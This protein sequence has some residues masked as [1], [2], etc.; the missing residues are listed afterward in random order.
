[1]KF[2]NRHV[3]YHACIALA[4]TLL[5]YFLLIKL[6]DE[7]GGVANIITIGYALTIAL[8]AILNNRADQYQG[9]FGLNYHL[10]TYIICVG[11]PLLLKACGIL[12]EVSFVGNMA[13]GWG[14]G[15]A[16]HLLIFLVRFRKRKLG[17]Y[18]KQE[19]FQ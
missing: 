13:L 12:S 5:L 3:L 10:V 8:S 11:L 4:A 14:I 7:Y 6:P 18:D 16:V 1:M 17:N 2:I 9:F 15:L 19:I